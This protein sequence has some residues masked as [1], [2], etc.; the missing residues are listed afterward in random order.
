[1]KVVILAGGFGTRIGE[2]SVLRPKPMIE[3][4]EK[5]LIWHIMKIYGYYGY[6]DFIILCGYKSY[7][8]KEYFFNYFLHQSDITVYTAKNEIEIHDTKS[9]EW[10]I[11]LL[12]TGIRTNTG[13]R[14]AKAKKYIGESTFMLTYGD[15]V[16]DINLDHLLSF[17]KCHKG[18]VTVT[19][20]RPEGRFGSLEINE[21]SKV[22]SFAEK[23][24]SNKQWINGGYFICDSRIFDYI[25]EDEDCIWEKKPLENL[26]KDGLIY[27]YKHDG[28]WKCMDTF[29]DK[30]HLQ[31]KW[32]GNPPWKIWQ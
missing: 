21:D 5:P 7:Y 15:G 20:V 11:T 25:S 26:A 3:I 13:S 29:R 4:G 2:E 22:L 6:N 31:K 14:I 18:A 1:M 28:F 24:E 9:E 17:H 30:I 23:T 10:K 19:S 32:E 27:A 12:D 16:C 8:I